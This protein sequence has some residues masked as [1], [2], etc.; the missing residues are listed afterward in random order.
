MSYGTFIGELKK[1]I[2]GEITA[3]DSKPDHD[4]C[5][6]YLRKSG[7]RIF[8]QAR[9]IDHFSK[10]AIPVLR[11]KIRDGL[12]A[13]PKLVLELTGTTLSFH[14]DPSVTPAG[15]VGAKAIGTRG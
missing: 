5:M 12:G 9:I 15:T 14:V 6:I 10:Q 3:Y 8:V 13:T 11:S 2:E 1:G 7:E 4:G